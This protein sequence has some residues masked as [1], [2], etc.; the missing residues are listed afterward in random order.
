MCVSGT[1]TDQDLIPL[2]GAVVDRMVDQTVLS[3]LTTGSGGEF[4]F[5][6]LSAGAYTVRASLSGYADDNETVTL[7]AGGWETVTLQLDEIRGS[8]SGVVRD[9]ETSVIIEGATV[10]AYDL[11]GNLLGSD[12]S[13]PTGRFLI[14]D[15]PLGTFDLRAW[16]DGYEMET[17]PDLQATVLAHDVDVGDVFLTPEAEPAGAAGLAD[18]WW[19]ILIIAVVVVLLLVLVAKRR[20]PEGAEEPSE[21]VEEVEEREEETIPEEDAEVLDDEDWDKML[22]ETLGGTE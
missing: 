22:E 18:Y 4:N 7:T 6:D 12:T 3:T 17:V 15:L 21:E 2:A 20:K 11:S 9:E 5:T 1:V 14:Q 13:T 16:A 19:V 10:E 8:V